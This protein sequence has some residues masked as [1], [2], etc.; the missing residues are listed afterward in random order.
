MA[1]QR[2]ESL[3]DLYL[4]EMQDLR[5]AEDQMA[6]VLPRMAG[7]ARDAPLR[8]T[9]EE[10]VERTERHRRTLEGI[11]GRM[12]ADADNVV[13]QGMRGLVVE[14]SKLMKRREMED[15]VLDAALIAATQKIEH[16]TIAG[17]GRLRAYAELLGEDEA[18]DALARILEEEAEMDDRLSD[19]AGRT[20]NRA[21]RA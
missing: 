21:A 4:H 12:D 18:R 16:Y 7:A 19:V 6:E 15:D 13:C 9:L 20:V 1:T 8:R 2:I 3:R 17:Y 11:L 10:S 14:A 5:D